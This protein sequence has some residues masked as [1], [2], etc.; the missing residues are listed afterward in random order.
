MQICGWCQKL[1]VREVS[2]L[3]FV[4]SLVLEA[5]G[6]GQDLWQLQFRCCYLEFR[7]LF[8]VWMCIIRAPS[9]LFTFFQQQFFAAFPSTFSLD[10]G[11]IVHHRHLQ[12]MERAHTSYCLPTPAQ[13]CT[14]PTVLWYIHFVFAQTFVLQLDCSILTPVTKKL[15]L[16]EAR[17]YTNRKSQFLSFH[18]LPLSFFGLDRRGVPPDFLVCLGH[19]HRWFL[20]SSWFGVWKCT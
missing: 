11:W 2:F 14:K 13:R 7:D 15:Y 18:E 1:Q 12:L 16:S 6:V 10:F 4:F 3:L 5:Q 8:L 19:F 17:K 20:R 9:F